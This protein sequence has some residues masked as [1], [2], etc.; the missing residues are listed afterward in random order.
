MNQGTAKTNIFTGDADRADFQ[1]RLS[2]LEDRFSLA[3][4]AFAQM[5]NHYHALVESRTG[6]LSRAMHWFDGTYARR[7][8]ERHGRVGALFRGRFRSKLVEDERYRTWLGPYIH[9]NPVADGFV[10]RPEDWEWSSYRGYVG[11][12]P[13][14]PWLHTD[15]LMV[16]D[17]SDYVRMTEGFIGRPVV[18]RFRDPADVERAAGYQSMPEEEVLAI[19]SF[20]RRVAAVYGVG[21]DMVR[22]S[23]DGVTA[24]R[25]AAIALAPKVLGLSLSET[26][27]V[28]ELSSRSSVV[29]AQQRFARRLRVNRDLRQRLLTS[30]LIT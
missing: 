5:G 12:V 13:R 16:G 24:P 27:S 21:V 30:G 11:L 17:S 20:E 2:L 1:E 15:L 28:Y 25:T 26:A 14:P 10:D 7:F 6:E 23:S 8:N 3:I 9:L 18:G 4:H 19:D 22:R 29:S